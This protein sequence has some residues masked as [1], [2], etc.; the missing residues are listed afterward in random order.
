MT[1]TAATEKS[2]ASVITLTTD[3]GLRDYYVAAVKGALLSQCRNVRIVDVSHEIT[4]FSIAE[5]AF[6]LRNAYPH[7]PKGSIHIFGVRPELDL[8]EG[9]YHVLIEHDGHF[10]IGADNGAFSLMF[11]HIPERIFELELTQDI[12]DMTFPTKDVF[13]KAACH[14]ARGGTPEVI[15]RAR[16]GLVE[17]SM[18][19]PVVD[20]KLIKG[21]VIYID[22]YGN[23]VTNITRALFKEVGKG[24]PFELVYHRAG[25]SIREISHAYHNVPRGDR[26]ALF[27]SAGYLEIAINS[28]AE[29]TGGGARGLLG[30]RVSQ[31]VRIEFL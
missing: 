20:Q 2:P 25:N 30:L 23:A 15:G 11:E 5:G 26:V 16:K 17:R 1:Y 28:G 10:F 6:V 29:Q 24:R 21:S 31:S 7:F 12:D 9:V 18:F 13:V 8:D 14:L 4:P 27:G 22:H 19:R 3:M